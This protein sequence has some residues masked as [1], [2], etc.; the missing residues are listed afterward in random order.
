MIVTFCGHA[1]F[2]KSEE[3]ERKILT[4]LKEKVGDQPA[5]M[6]LGGYGAFDSFAYD[7]C[8]KYKGTH[9]NIS[10]VFVTPYLSVEYQ[11]NHLYYQQTRYD[12]ILYPEIE[13][14][15]PRFAI[16]YRNRWMIEQ[17]DYVICGITH[18][19]G[20]AYQTYQYA[21]RKKKHIFNVTE[22]NI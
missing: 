8:K 19:W 14:K 16:I 17:A 21:K 12:S 18:D 10:L 22:K 2:S 7:C 5:D 1:H 3:Y 11:K 15:P 6:F 20:G 4:F 9:P 13:D